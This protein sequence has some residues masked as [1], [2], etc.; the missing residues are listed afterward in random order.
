MN[1]RSF[2]VATGAVIGGFCRGI[3]AALKPVEASSL[4]PSAELPSTLRWDDVRGQFNLHPTK[5]NMACLWHASHPRPVRT[6][7]DRHRAG[8]DECP[9]EYFHENAPRMEAEVRAAAAD[10]LHGR[11]DEIALT[12]STSEG[13]GTIYAGLKLRPEQE[14]LSTEQDHIQTK[15][16]LRLRAE[17][18]G[19]KVKTISLYERSD[20][21]TEDQLVGCVVQAITDRTKV[22]AITWVQSATGV[23]MPVAQV[24]REVSRLN[25][26]RE[27]PDRILLCVDGVHG[28][29]VEDFEIA[30]LGCDFFI[31]G[32][33]KW[34]FGPRGTG[35]VWGKPEAWREV[36]ATIPTNDQLWTHLPEDQLTPA[37][38]MT[39][40][41]F[42]TF[43][44]RWALTEAF[45]FHRQIGK[46]RVTSRI[47]EL[48]TQCKEGLSKMPHVQ[49]HTPMSERLSAGMV[50]F[51]V[52]GLT[53]EQTVARLKEKGIIA[54]TTPP[55]KHEYARVTPSLWNT[56]AEVETT[57]RAIRSLA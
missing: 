42:H 51:D 47:H 13:L 36:I 7:I 18:T 50:C 5:I 53:P 52:K 14:I 6:A 49:L 41:G 16:S 12:G 3:G 9:S 44:H 56:P 22:I 33:H 48:N 21:V 45:Q 55:Y 28:F 40:G 10:Y 19:A 8:L 37:S 30:D 1:R 24:A 38:L 26:A 31:A 27:V 54:S 34:L 57:L 11:H 2:M 32:C 39:P 25:A 4:L 46:N 20:T 23:K 17:K 15:S 29:G 43:E 35:L